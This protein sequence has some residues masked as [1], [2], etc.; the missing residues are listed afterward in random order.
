MP[1]RAS[2]RVLLAPLH[3]STTLLR[4]HAFTP[5]AT[6]CN[7]CTALRYGVESK[8]GR[9]NCQISTPKRAQTWP[10]ARVACKQEWRQVAYLQLASTWV[11]R[12]ATMSSRN[13]IDVWK[14]MDDSGLPPITLALPLGTFAFLDIA[15]G[16]QIHRSSRVDAPN[17]SESRL[18]T[19]AKNYVLATAE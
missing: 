16:R 8:E 5:I 6:L 11:L 3:R 19:A 18:K 7:A 2:R 14:I 1:Q 9:F 17:V 15:A 12:S 4:V 10:E 13:M